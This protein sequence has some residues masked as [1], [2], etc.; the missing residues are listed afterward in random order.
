M[1]LAI[2]LG[3]VAGIA[4]FAPLYV[5]LKRS[6]T[7]DAQSSAIGYL[8]PLLLKA[9]ASIVVLVICTALCIVVA[10]SMALPF[11]VSEAAVL[12]VCALGF[13]IVRIVSNR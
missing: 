5:G 9:A 4:S 2:V 11:V 6:R 13:G 12:I 8:S 1:V 7:M 3:I 10:R